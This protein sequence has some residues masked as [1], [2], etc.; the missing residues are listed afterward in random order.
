MAIEIACCGGRDRLQGMAK[1]GLK[2]VEFGLNSITEMGD[3]DFEKLCA[4]MKQRGLHCRTVNGFFPWTMRLVGSERDLDA[5]KN[6]LEKAMA[7]LETLGVKVAVLGCGGGRKITDDLDEAMVRRE[8]GE[9]VLMAAEATGEVGVKVAIESLNTRECNFL[10]TVKDTAAYVRA[11]K[12][13]EIDGLQ[14]KEGVTDNIGVLADFYHMRMDSEPMENLECAGDL[15]LHT[16]IARNGDRAYPE[17]I[18]E[19]LYIEFFEILRKIGY[20]GL[21]SIEGEPKNFE[22]DVARAAEVLSEAI[23]QVS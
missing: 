16:H 5:I 9:V 13:N 8:F 10:T 7:R 19:D 23:E 20:E 11:L 1:A 15:L 22:E 3:A 21:T 4:E 2:Y 14:V 18:D 12:A 6:Y 17:A